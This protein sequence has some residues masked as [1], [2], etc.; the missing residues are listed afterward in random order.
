MVFAVVYSAIGEMLLTRFGELYQQ[1]FVRIS[2]WCHSLRLIEQ[3]PFFGY[4]FDKPLNFL[5]DT[6]ELNHTTHS[7]YLGALLKGAVW[8]SYCCSRCWEAALF[9]FMLVFY[10]SQVMLVIANPA[11]FWYLFWL[12][13]ALLMSQPKRRANGPQQIATEADVMLAILRVPAPTL[14]RPAC[15]AGC[16]S[17]NPSRGG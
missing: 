3:A 4:G 2:I 10:S 17:D 8:G 16:P 7:L 6:G 11:E 14:P 12:P 1:S 9:L 13:L 15:C 5:N